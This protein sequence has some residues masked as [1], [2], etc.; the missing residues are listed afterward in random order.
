MGVEILQRADG[1]TDPGKH[2]PATPP[3]AWHHPTHV[4]ACAPGCGAWQAARFRRLRL[5]GPLKGDPGQKGCPTLEATKTLFHPDQTVLPTT[6]ETPQK[7]LQEGRWASPAPRWAQARGGARCGLCCSPAFSLGTTAETAADPQAPRPG[8]GHKG[9]GDRRCFGRCFGTSGT[10]TQLPVRG[11]FRSGAH[12]QLRH[13]RSRQHRSQCTLTQ[14]PVRGQ[15][16][17]RAHAQLRHKRSRQHR[18]QWKDANS[19]AHRW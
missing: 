12:A 2:T 19:Q 4:P 10:L 7:H 18:S 1:G 17:S 14:L 16:R 8:P 6:Q 11:Q 13:K 5:E 15:F 3:T 9:V